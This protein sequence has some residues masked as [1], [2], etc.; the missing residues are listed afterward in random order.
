MK[1]PKRSRKRRHRLENLEARQLL[2]LN[3]LK[4]ANFF[5]FRSDQDVDIRVVDGRLEYRSGAGDF[6]S[7]ID[8]DQPGDQPFTLP[9]GEEVTTIRVVDTNATG[10]IDVGVGPID[11]N[12]ANLELGFAQAS[13]NSDGEREQG[14]PRGPK[15]QLTADIETSGGD[16]A[17][18]SVDEVQVL[19][20]ITISTRADVSDPTAGDAG[21]LAIRVANDDRFNPFF[22][23]DAVAINI[24]AGARLLADAVNADAG[25]VSLSATN[26]NFSLD[27]LIFNSLSGLDRAATIRLDD[28]EILAGNIDL[29]ANTGDINLISDRL[30]KLDDKEDTEV[31]ESVAGEWAAGLLQSLVFKLDDIVSLPATVSVRKSTSDIQV[32]GSTLVAESDID[33]NATTKAEAFGEATYFFSS[34]FGVAVSVMYAEPTAI[35]DL[36]SSE[37][38]AGRDVQ[39]TSKATGVADGEAKVKQN[40]KLTKQSTAKESVEFAFAV[41]VNRP[42]SELLFDADS[43]IIADGNVKLSS[44][45]SNTTKSTATTTSF[46]DGTAGITFALN[47]TE[48][49]IRTEVDGDITANS[50]NI[51]DVVT[52]NPLDDAVIDFANG[53]IN[54]TTPHEFEDGDE[55]VYDS[56]LAAPLEG[57]ESGNRYTIKVVDE[58]T[59][60]LQS[61]DASGELQTVSFGGAYSLLHVGNRSLPIVSIED[62][63][64]IVFPDSEHQ[65]SSGESVSIQSAPGG[66]IHRQIGDELMR[67][68]G[69]QVFTAVVDPGQ[70][71]RLVLIDDQNEG[72]LLVTDSVFASGNNKYR[73]SG[74]SIDDDN[75]TLETIDGEDVLLPPTAALT[76]TQGLADRFAGLTDGE[77]YHLVRFA[78]E[79]STYRL[80]A[81]ADHATR[82]VQAANELAALVV[83]TLEAEDPAPEQEAIEDAA[84]DAF[85]N[86]VSETLVDPDVELTDDFDSVVI[87]LRELAEHVTGAA[88][89]LRPTGVSGITITAKLSGTEGGK[90]GGGIG[91][92]PKARNA[93]TGD[94]GDA[95]FLTSAFS[96]LFASNSTTDPNSPLGQIENSVNQA[97]ADQKAEEFSSS[98]ESRIG[99]AASI[100]IHYSDNSIVTQ[101][102]QDATL[103]SGRD[104]EIGAVAKVKTSGSASGSV[105]FAE[106]KDAKV[107]VAAALMVGIYNNNV[108]TLVERGVSLNAARN[109]TVN[110]KKEY[111]FKFPFRDPSAFDVDSFFAKDPVKQLTTLFDGKFGLQSLFVHHTTQTKASASTNVDNAIAAS[112]QY[113]GYSGVSEAIIGWESGSSDYSGTTT[114]L[115]EELPAAFPALNQSVRV[116][117]E[118]LV[119]TIHLVGNFSIGFTPEGLKK[120]IKKKD[121]RKVFDTTPTRGSKLGI[122][123]TA[124]VLELDHTTRAL[125]VGPTIVTANDL[126]ADALTRTFSLRL[127]QAGSSAGKAAIAGTI[128]VGLGQQTTVAQIDDQVTVEAEQITINAV[129]DSLIIGYAGG[130]VTGEAAGF[131]ITVAVNDIDRTTRAIAGHALDQQA[132]GTPVAWNT[133]SLTVSATNDGQIAGVSFAAAI[134]RDKKGSSSSGSSSGGNSS[135]GNNTGGDDDGGAFR[136][137]SLFGSL[138]DEDS[139]D[140]SVD[141]NRLTED[142]TTESGDQAPKP[143]DEDGKDYETNPRGQ[144]ALSPNAESSTADGDSTTEGQGKFGVAVSGNVSVNLLSDV[145]ESSIAGSLIIGTANEQADVVHVDAENNTLNITIGGAFAFSVKQDGKNVGIAGAVSYN[146]LDGKT[147]AAIYDATLNVHDVRVDSRRDGVSGTFTAGAAGASQDKGIAVAGSVSINRLNADTESI[148]QGAT[149]TSD[150]SVALSALDKSQIVSIAGAGS[151]GGKAG[152]GA[153]VSYNELG[154]QTTALLGTGSD[155]TLQRSATLNIQATSEREKKRDP[156]A[157]AQPRIVSVTGA[158]GVSKDSVGVA[159]MVSVNLMN[160]VTKAAIESATVTHVLPANLGTD[161]TV[162]SQDQSWIV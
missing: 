137:L 149:I 34:K 124:D 25:D 62:D 66:V 138:A 8:L 119:D 6:S 112:I 92:T 106:N 98:R 4:D 116:D 26:V 158:V 86:A 142:I 33:V 39:L 77:T 45:G 31:D 95:S 64:I 36:D 79:D 15:L 75:V 44:E 161:V 76:F 147:L 151:F 9:L 78:G 40:T 91:G 67:L 3:I 43:T 132:F 159:G 93:L 108:Q 57:L 111:P 55:V 140:G 89:E 46:V 103:I 5:E 24:G 162:R 65:I 74:F 52:F 118:T 27:S 128:S 155:V 20:G 154:G 144:A 125:I 96:G 16:I 13:D 30:K 17:F 29:D 68:D 104:L 120:A 54:F 145:V 21:D 51:A 143:D 126:H 61:E 157:K 105:S 130:V 146:Q 134:V 23:I 58:T 60:Q 69:S 133:D 12:G 123:G 84:V 87:D 73:L 148:V 1:N 37:L 56:G 129:D 99:V 48:A 141:S 18:G 38:V 82:A 83:A 19:P 150:E 35:V 121:V 117:A 7:D 115:N 127:D 97:T 49:N 32:T 109:L 160:N 136:L 10:T 81:D 59:L 131:G 11:T 122:G 72:V 110:A 102:G 50:R 28:A 153:A 63:G 114:R 22:N 101:V 88:H 107:G 41:G 113:V 94:T 100:L 139:D 135:G 71:D 90:A 2:A 156:D 70:P 14:R 42:R 53:E 152:V 85:N 80:T 47:Y